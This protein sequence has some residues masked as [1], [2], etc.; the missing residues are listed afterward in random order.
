MVPR[1]NLGKYGTRDDS[2]FYSVQNKCQQRLLLLLL[3][4]DDETNEGLSVRHGTISMA[5][6]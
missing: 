6:R 2:C 4:I 5:D 3:V 1:T